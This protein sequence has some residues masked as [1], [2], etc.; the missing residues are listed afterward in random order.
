[1]LS[2][3]GIKNGNFLF[4][5][6]RMNLTPYENNLKSHFNI[7]L[8]YLLFVLLIVFLILLALWVEYLINIKIIQ[9]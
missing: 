8:F 6:N 2:F 7:F 4:L 1:M 3:S 9:I 5:L